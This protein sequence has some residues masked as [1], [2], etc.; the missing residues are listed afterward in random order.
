MNLLLHIC[1][2]PCIAAPLAELRRGG[3][4]VTGFFHN[5]NIH[6]LLEFRKRLRAVEV[7]AEQEKLGLIGR[8]EYGLH[9]FL[10]ETAGHER[11]PEGGAR[12]AIC[13]RMRINATAALARRE[14][15]DA[16]TT[17]MLFSRHQ[18]HELISSIAREAA[19]REGV[20]FHYADLR[21]MVEA[22]MEIARKRSLYRQQY[23]GCIFSEYERYEGRREEDKK[24]R[25][26]R[27]TT[28]ERKNEGGEEGERGTR[29]KDSGAETMRS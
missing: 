16:F 12:C 10:R 17:S 3:A 23:C 19:A 9:E 2:A 14:R 25:R 18:N 11:D 27:A 4:E 28:G 6:P 20:A 29:D 22:S 8:P 26:E 7:L 5:P 13:Y 1:C 15:F 24:G 21:D